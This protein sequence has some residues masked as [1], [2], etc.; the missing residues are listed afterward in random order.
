MAFGAFHINLLSV[1]LCLV[2]SLVFILVFAVKP[3]SSQQYYYQ[4]SKHKT[5]DEKTPWELFW[6]AIG[7]IGS[8]GAVLMGV[9]QFT[10]V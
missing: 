6:L 2:A 10:R 8:V 1:I 4:I 3:R 5:Y 9:Y 7:I